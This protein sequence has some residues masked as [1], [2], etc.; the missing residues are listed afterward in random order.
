M[1]WP[2]SL[3]GMSFKF[4]H[5]HGSLPLARMRNSDSKC[6]FI[7]YLSI[8]PEDETPFGYLLNNDEMGS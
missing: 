7:I 4:G 3:R 2:T 6:R 1:Y 8:K 5:K